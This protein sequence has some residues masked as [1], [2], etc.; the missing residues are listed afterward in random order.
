MQSVLCSWHR[1][2]FHRLPRHSGKDAKRVRLSAGGLQCEAPDPDEGTSD[3]TGPSCQGRPLAW[4][5]LA[6]LGRGMFAPPV[7]ACRLSAFF[8]RDCFFADD[9][10]NDVSCEIRVPV[11]WVPAPILVIGPPRRLR[12]NGRRWG[13]VRLFGPPVDESEFRRILELAPNTL[14]CLSLKPSGVL[15]DDVSRGNR[16]VPALRRRVVCRPDRSPDLVS[17]LFTPS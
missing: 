2:D 11:K 17:C 6:Q 5:C 15:V 3:S 14:S 9:L 12:S 8:F 16:A 10:P 13:S 7:S 1:R 4:A